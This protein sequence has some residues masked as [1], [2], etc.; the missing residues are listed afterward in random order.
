MYWVKSCIL[1]LGTS[2]EATRVPRCI[3]TE[4]ASAGATPAEMMAV[5]GGANPASIRP[6]LVQTREQEAAFQRKR[7]AY[8]GVGG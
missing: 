1:A 2:P 8:R 6:Y 7:D 4:G 5:G 3:A